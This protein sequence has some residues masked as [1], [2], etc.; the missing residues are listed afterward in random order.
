MDMGRDAPW[1]QITLPKFTQ[2]E[3]S[4]MGHSVG[5]YSSGDSYN[6]GGKKAFLTGEA[7]VYSLR[8]SKTGK[9][10]ITVEIQNDRP[11]KVGEVSNPRINGIS[12]EK[13]SAPPINDVLELAKNKGVAVENMP[14]SLMYSVDAEGN[15]L[16]DRVYIKWQSLYK[17]YLQNGSPTKKAKGGNVERVYNDRKY[18]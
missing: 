5:G 9:P 14:L 2:I 1:F 7:Q 16:A 4:A 15:A 8:N 10:S 13:N 18:I 17:E 6:L 11:V 12:G 3:G